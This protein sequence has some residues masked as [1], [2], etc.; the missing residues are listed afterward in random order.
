MSYT[1]STTP[2]PAAASAAAY[3]I[4]TEQAHVIINSL[5]TGATTAGIGALAR[6]VM[7]TPDTAEGRRTLAG[8]MNEVEHALTEQA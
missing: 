1:D 2:L 5:R 7:D 3:A 8:L 4:G 6:I